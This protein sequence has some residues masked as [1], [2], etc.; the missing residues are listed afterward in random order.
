MARE[1]LQKKALSK[2]EYIKGFAKS[3]AF[4]LNRKLIDKDSIAPIAESNRSNR[5]KALFDKHESDKSSGHDY[6]LFYADIL[7]TIPYGDLLEIGIGTNNPNLVSTMGEAG[8]PGA[9]LFAWRE[10]GEFGSVFGAD[11]DRSILFQNEEGIT[12][13]YVDQTS[14]S[15]LQELKESLSDSKIVMVIDDGLHEV[16]ANLVAFKELWSIVHP[17]GAY[18]IEDIHEAN[19]I[20]LIIGLA[21]Y[22]EN[23]DWYIYQNYNKKIDNAILCIKKGMSE[24]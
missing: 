11:I 18:C 14:K 13:F 3:R 4:T 15:D 20:P 19:L 8:K 7:T 2:W 5:L 10:S 16:S 9:S 1:I 6:H 17:G 21:S 22:M 12:T 23:S 24:Q